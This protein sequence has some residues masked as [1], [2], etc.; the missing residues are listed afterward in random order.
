[1]AASQGPFITGK[2]QLLAMEYAETELQY[3]RA[4]AGGTCVHLA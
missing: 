3:D 1:M 4:L 2:V